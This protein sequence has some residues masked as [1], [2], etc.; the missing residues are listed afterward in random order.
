MRKN[1]FAIAS[2]LLS[3]IPVILP[4]FSLLWT[5]INLPGTPIQT[6]EPL[7]IAD[8]EIV[9]GGEIKDTGETASIKGITIPGLLGVFSYIFFGFLPFTSFFLSS[10]L[11]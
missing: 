4:F 1:K 11:F 7:E 6:V 2:L 3:L 9:G 10:Q 8:G 5:V